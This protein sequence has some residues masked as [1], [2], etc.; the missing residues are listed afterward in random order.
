LAGLPIE[1]TK[2]WW[3][4]GPHFEAWVRDYA[5]EGTVWLAIVRDRLADPNAFGEPV[6]TSAGG[7]YALFRVDAAR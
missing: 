6:V 2:R 3:S 1:G 7:R 4:T 5:R